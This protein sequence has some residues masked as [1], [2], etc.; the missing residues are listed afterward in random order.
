MHAK[1][2]REASNSAALTLPTVNRAVLDFD[3]EKRCS[4]TL[5]NNDNIYCCCICGKFFLGKTVQTPASRHALEEGHFVFISL[6]SGKFYCLP[7][8][9]EIVDASLKDIKLALYPE[10]L[11]QEIQN[12]DSAADLAVDVHHESYLPCFVGLN[13]LGDSS[14]FNAAV[15]LLLRVRHLRN[16][17]LSSS[18]NSVLKSHALLERLMHLVRRLC[19]PHNFRRTVSPHELLQL[20]SAL[21]KKRF[22]VD[23]AGDAAELLAWLLNSLEKHIVKARRASRKEEGQRWK[24]PMHALRE[25][26]H[27]KCKF[28]QWGGGRNVYR[29]FQIF[30]LRPPSSATSRRG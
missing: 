11:P 19:S 6:S 23:K 29:P 22:A 1:R 24:N 15:Q 14:Y 21:S 16:F 30:V 20:I 4:V 9:Y 18:N 26:W 28:R 27:C 12:L 17:F 5:L 25:R 13:N 7:D 2:R 8:N 10:F 3:H